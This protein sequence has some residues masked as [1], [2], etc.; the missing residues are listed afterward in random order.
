MP[1]SS[2][3]L[4]ELVFVIVVIGILSAMII[5][6]LERDSIFEATTQVLNHIKYTQ[7]LA[8][9]EDVYNDQINNWFLSRWKIQFFSCGGYTVY[10]DQNRLGGAPAQSDAAID[11][12]TKKFLFTTG[13]CTENAQSYE[14]VVLSTYYDIVGNAGTSAFTLSA[15]CPAQFISFDTLGRPYG[16]N[17]ING[18]LKQNCEIILTSGTGRSETIR[19]HPETGYACIL[20]TASNSCI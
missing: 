13:L 10:S 3:T 2:F 19:I 7:H 16:T 20:N 6:R 1:K 11:P 8:M 17:T 18:V 15:G 9:T 12:Q 14:K 5:P 4:I